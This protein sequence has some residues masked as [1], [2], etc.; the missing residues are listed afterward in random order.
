[1]HLNLLGPF[2]VL[3]AF[4]AT[5]ASAATIEE[6]SAHLLKWLREEGGF[7]HPD[8]EMRRL[9]STDPASFF[10][11]F[12][13][14]DISIDELLITV[15]TSVIV[16]SGE[17]TT[18]DHT[19]L[20]CDTIIN[21]THQL[22]LGDKSEYAPYVNYLLETQHAGQLPSGW[23]KAGKKLL[24]TVLGGS[25][26]NQNL[27][28]D[29][30]TDWMEDYY[31]ECGGD[32]DDEL[33]KF[34][35]LL[36][37]QRGWDNLLLP[38]YDMMSHRNGLWLNTK[39]DESVHDGNPISVEAKRD[40]KAGEQIYTSYNMCE[41]CSN[42][43]K[44]YGTSEILRD[45]GFVEGYPQQW[46][47][48]DIGIRFRLDETE[49]DGGDI[50]LTEWVNHEEADADDVELMMGL[51]EQIQETINNT[52]KIRDTE[53]PDYEWNL[54]VEYMN[55]MEVALD[56]A[57]NHASTS[58]SLCKEE[59][60]C[61]VSLDRYADLDTYF[62]SYVT[63]D[64]QGHECDID[65]QFTVFSEKFDDLEDVQSQYQHI[66]FSWDPE[67][68][69]TCMDLD[70]VLQICDSYRPHY[71]EMVVHNTARFLPPN[72]IKRVLWVG[73]GDSMLLHEIL[74]YP[75]LELVVGLELDQK[76]TRGAYKHFGTQPHY[77]QNKV[78]WWYGDASKSLL[79]LP[80]DYFGSFDM[81]L[82]DLSETVM[83]FKVTKE[84]DVLEA[85]NLL[86][87]PDGIF[88]KNEVYFEKFTS[89]FPHS[90]QIN[91][92]DNP[93]ICSQVLAMGSRNLD[94]TKPTLTDHGIESLFLRPLDEIEDDFG[95]F[96]SYSRNNT[97]RE[98]CDVIV[99]EGVE[100]IDEQVRSP[101]IVL[102]V[103]VEDVT[104]EISDTVK[105][106]ELLTETLVKQ[107]LNIV[108]KR[109]TKDIEDETDSDS[110]ITLV[111]SEG[112]VI[113]RSMPELQYCGIDIHFWSAL[114]K[115]ESTK[116]ALVNALGSSTKSGKS[117]TAF[118]VI[119]GG[120]FGVPT[121]KDDEKSR[122][123][124]YKE[125]CENIEK[126]KIEKEKMAIDEKKSVD[127]NT[128]SAGML[129]LLFNQGLKVAL[130]CGNDDDEDCDK[131]Y[132][133]L[134]DVTSVKKVVKLSCPSLAT[135]NPFASDASKI[136]TSC[137]DY[138]LEAMKGEAK[139]GTFDAIVIDQSADKTTAAVLHRI[140]TSR[141]TFRKNV[142]SSEV[143]VIAFAASEGDEWRK[144]LLKRIKQEVFEYD[145]AYYTDIQ[146][147]ANDQ[148]LILASDGNFGFMQQ[149]NTT[150]T[151]LQNDN[152]VISNIDL[153]IGGFW[154]YQHD[155]VP[156]QHFLPDDFDQDPSLTQWKSQTPLG[157]QVIMQMEV[158]PSSGLKLSS[159]ILREGLFKAVDSDSENNNVT[160]FDDLGDGCLLVDTWRGGSIVVLWDG[161]NHVDINLF[162]YEEDF[163]QATAFEENFSLAIPGLQT[164]LRDEHPRGMGR[165]VSF[166]KDIEE[167]EEPH[168]A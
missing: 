60:A 151:Q 136:I 61:N 96:H 65:D 121:W 131:S 157:Y 100:E 97:F 70:N 165:V 37:I 62:E 109:V 148:K 42:R 103:E 104:F 5:V 92:Y 140:M 127:S 40:I 58:S 51:L 49:P 79:M 64:Y 93:I 8:L 6:H 87:K 134:Q 22:Y 167:Y 69:D 4:F 19:D 139:D 38:V 71:H 145:P 129:D 63:D 107:G 102:V 1:M 154:I 46:I 112:Y 68:R 52:L 53:V 95:L 48:H 146:V 66:E 160:E 76:V 113:V 159:K 32:K 2:L 84:L 16:D 125:L 101:G 106:V 119:A 78:Q 158:T 162:T 80:K 163:E 34:A 29:Y 55:A 18:H 72:S 99:G 164:M 147:G 54:V 26:P 35:A 7:F 57:I 115:H 56:V 110:I 111:L 117:L 166:E 123:P 31:D 59:G 144:T 28:P 75:S 168:W 86:V 116:N 13:K 45:Y 130:I 77:D 114:D 141:K 33:G 9:D 156:T 90:V 83:S 12:A 3:T 122:G 98:I 74:K 126:S 135:F 41:D 17:V 47:F 150:L 39:C 67:T 155:F 89:M 132:I 30:P 25:G 94:F 161:R 124:Q 138:L 142:L 50:V 81:V 82:V 120:M 24:Q 118:R 36:V 108:S 143:I 153:L 91:W 23:S 15:P 27:P 137:E 14:N 88:V 44:S 43:V 85:L 133:T 11:M 73:G 20:Q 152:G 21:L 10:G 128:V 105:L 149:L